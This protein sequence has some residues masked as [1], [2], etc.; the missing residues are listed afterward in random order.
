MLCNGYAGWIVG[1]I[2]VAYPS[3][4]ARRSARVLWRWA[5]LC[6]DV[7]HEIPRCCIARLPPTCV[8]GKRPFFLKITP[9][10]RRKTTSPIARSEM[11]NSVMLRFVFA[12]RENE[13]YDCTYEEY[14]RKECH[15]CFYRY[16]CW[17]QRYKFSLT[18]A[19]SILR[20]A[21]KS[22]ACRPANTFTY[23]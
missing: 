5:S 7:W 17:E 9:I 10:E 13:K 3:L 2:E 4:A 22:A 18:K 14:Y 16:I 8:L 23:T 20:G 11:R 19:L 12:F 21:Q 1:A 15:A 6:C